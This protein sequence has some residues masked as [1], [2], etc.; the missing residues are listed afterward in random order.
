MSLLPLAIDLV[1]ALTLLWLAWRALTSPDLFRAVVLFIA[2][3]LV[4]GLVWVRL[5][6]VDIALAEIALGAGVTGA[7]L[8]AAL[9]KLQPAESQTDEVAMMAPIALRL[10]IALLLIALLTGLGLVVW[11]LWV[12]APGLSNLVDARLDESGVAYPVTAVLLNFRGYD[13]LLELAVLLLALIGVWSLS[14]ASHLGDEEPEPALA[15]LSRL[16]APLMILVAA[17]LVWVGAYAPGGAFQAGSVLGAAGVLLRLSGWRLSLS[18]TGW[19]LRLV[20]VLGVAVFAFIGLAVIGFGQPLL[21]YPPG[22]AKPAILT[23][24]LAATLSIGAILAALFIG[25]RP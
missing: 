25:G 10:P 23:I 7:L 3:G 15:A 19:P 8:L 12:P 20:L 11:Q 1:L 5:D 9:A 21:G 17:Y 2:L 6:A 13:T 14:T 22:W 16:L 4:L 18:A 24:E